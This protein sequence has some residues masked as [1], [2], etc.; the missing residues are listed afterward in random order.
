MLQLVVFDL[1]KYKKLDRV[2]QLSV[3]GLLLFSFY[4][5]TCSYH[6]PP[7]I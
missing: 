6:F 2:P 3:L 7:M 5:F 1:G 4:M